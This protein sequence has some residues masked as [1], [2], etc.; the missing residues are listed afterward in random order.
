MIVLVLVK[1]IIIYFILRNFS[2]KVISTI[3]ILYGPHPHLTNH[4]YNRY[5]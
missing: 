5:G 4:W 2:I 3:L 1:I